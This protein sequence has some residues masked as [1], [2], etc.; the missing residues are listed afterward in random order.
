MSNS[1]KAKPKMTAMQ[2]LILSILL[3]L[4]I[5]LLGFLLMMAT[6]KMELPI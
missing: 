6:G 3:F 1:P 4:T 2:K 5:L